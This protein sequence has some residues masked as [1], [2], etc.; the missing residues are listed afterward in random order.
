MNEFNI[1]VHLSF[2]S[3]TL[4]PG[5]CSSDLNIHLTSDLAPLELTSSEPYLV[6]EPGETGEYQI[7]IK[8]NQGIADTF[9]ISLNSNLDSATPSTNSVVLSSGSET[10]ITIYESGL[11]PDTEWEPTRVL[12]EL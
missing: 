10:N 11:F 5:T 1:S 2:F 6:V 9:T 8:N 3:S 12:L 7:T 4:G